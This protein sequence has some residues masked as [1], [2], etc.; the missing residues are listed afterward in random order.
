MIDTRKALIFIKKQFDDLVNTIKNGTHDTYVTNLSD[1][2]AIKFPTIQ[3]V[4][5]I[6]DTTSEVLEDLN[7]TL[8]SH[9]MN[10][11]DKIEPVELDFTSILDKLDSLVDKDINKGIEELLTSISNK[12][13]DFSSLEKQLMNIEDTL[14]SSIKNKKEKKEDGKIYEKLIDGI[15]E[16]LSNIYVPT[17]PKVIG[18]NNA[19]GTRINPSTEEKQ[20]DIITAVNA[21]SGLQRSTNMYGTGLV[22]VGT[23]AVEVEITGTP[24]SMTIEYPAIAANTGT[25]YIG[26]SNVTN[27][28]ANAFK[29]LTAGM[30]IDIDYD[31][32]TNAIY[33]VSDTAAQSFIAGGLI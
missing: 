9:L 33:V 16:T 23:T 11:K 3:S 14:K 26:K 21:F 29:S 4:N 6:G 19:A 31:D 1:I 12:D 32:T 25:L 18:S 27:A 17:F 24:E 5:V 28:G 2:P 20:D 8:S 22:S 13:V 10:I 30:S 15:K 7:S